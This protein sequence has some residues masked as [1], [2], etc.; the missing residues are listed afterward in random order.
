MPKVELKHG[1]FG[2]CDL[3][4]HDVGAA[5][6]FF[7][8]LF[9]WTS[10]P[11]THQDQVVYHMFR[12]GDARVAGLVDNK[13]WGGEEQGP[14]PMWVSYVIVDD[15]DAL[16]PR[17]A[18]LGGTVLRPPMDVMESG[19]MCFIQDPTGAMVG[20]WEPREH[21]GADLFNEAGTLT[22]NELVTRD[23]EGARTFYEALLGWEWEVADMESTG[24]YHM[25]TVGGRPTGGIIEMPPDM[26]GVPANWVVYFHVDDVDAALERARELGGTLVWG[27]EEAEVGKFAVVTDPTGGHFNLFTPAPTN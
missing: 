24:P 8:E 18:E 7:G 25:G 5:A 21:L 4:T 3:A 16:A 12:L 26:E 15:V 9:G 6:A 2:W 17:V 22:W 10:E 1:M 14:P 23:V 11:V 19:R 13:G 27:P 20:L